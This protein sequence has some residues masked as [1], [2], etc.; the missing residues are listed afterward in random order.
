[1]EKKSIIFE[2][3]KGNFITGIFAFLPLVLTVWIIDFLI[4]KINGLVLGVTPDFL[5]PIVSNNSYGIVLRIIIFIL[6]LIFITIVGAL[7]KVY[8]GKR[9]FKIGEDIIRRIP[10]MNKIYK[11]IHQISEAFFGNK[12]NYSKVVLVEFPRKGTYSIGFLTGETK[13]EVQ[14]LIKDKLYNVF[15]PTTPNPTSGFLV[16]VPEQDLIFSTMTAEEGMKML[17][18][19][20]V[21]IPEIKVKKE[22]NN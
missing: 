15:I 13:G 17:I 2:D 21:V 16:F 19:G 12:S 4:S 8:V 18:S 1:M 9:L 5:M 3:L 14:N 7:T 11:L 10:V 20:G 22:E 6:I